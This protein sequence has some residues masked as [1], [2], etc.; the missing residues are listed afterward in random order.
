LKKIHPTAIIHQHAEIGEN[1]VVGPYC[2]IGKDV[3]LGDNNILYSNVIIDG[4]TIIGSGNKFYHSAVIGTDCQDLK[5]KGEP[6]K[7]IIGNNNTFR[8]FSTVNKSATME[9]PTQVGN[10]CLLMAYTHIAHNCILSNNIIMANAVNLA[11]HIHIHDHVIIGGLTAITQFIK[12]GTHAF[13]GGASG[14]KKD[15]PPYTRGIGFPYKVSGLN[16]VG[17]QR[18]G[19]TSEQIKSIKDVYK[20]FYRS[21]LNVSQ[22]LKKVEELQDLSEEQQ[23][24]IEFIRNSDNGI[25]R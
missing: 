17:L 20:I 21:N 7:L 14:V 2:I 25:C 6:T 23:T 13:V 4:D 1:T 9:E 15:I 16:I 19:F 18:K 22:A 3:K 8:E 11:G 10:N 12:I 24:F 5:Y